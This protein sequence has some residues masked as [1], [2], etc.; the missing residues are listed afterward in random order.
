MTANHRTD[1]L[2]LIGIKGIPLIK[3]GDD[4][5]QIISTAI[6]D[7]GEE[8]RPNDIL[9]V[10]QKVVS[11]AEGRLFRL[12]TISPSTEARKLAGQTGKDPRLVELILRESA[13]VVRVRDGLIITEH[14]LGFIMANAGVDQSNVESDSALLLPEDSDASARKL[15]DDLQAVSG[16]RLAIIV[17]DSMG[18]A[19]RNGI[20]GHAIGVAGIQALV[21]LRETPD[22]LGRKLRVTEVALADEIAAAATL[23]MGQGSEGIPVV[24]VRG[25]SGFSRQG[26]IA[27]LIR[28]KDKDL[29]R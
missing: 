11:K 18:R 7:A 9:V 4:L 15:L 19:W 1:R 5:S 2:E 23:I 28:D 25:F 14:K 8:L 27:D 26:A 12:E 20:V 21:D 3:A 16:G 17:A 24:V 29:F 10:A 22:L 13:D 6:D